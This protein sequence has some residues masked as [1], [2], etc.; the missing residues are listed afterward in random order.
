MSVTQTSGNWL[1]EDNNFQKEKEKKTENK[2]I[3]G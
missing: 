2:I 3:W 1:S